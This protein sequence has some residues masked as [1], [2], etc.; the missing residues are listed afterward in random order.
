LP[1][2]GAGQYTCRRRYITI[3]ARYCGL[4]VSALLAAGEVAAQARVVERH[5]FSD[6]EGRLLAFYS[7]S[8]AFS[9]A[10]VGW[11]DSRLSF[12]LEVSHVPYLDK[13]QRRPSIDKPESTNLAPFFPRPR[14]SIGLGSWRAEASWIPPMRV[15]DVQANLG[16]LSITAPPVKI[17]TFRLS[18]RAWATIGRVEGAMTCSS[19]EML[20]H[21][22]DLELYYGTVCHGRESEDWFE[23]RMVG[24]EA[25]IARPLGS[26]GSSVYALAGAR[27]DR[28]RFDIGVLTFD[29]QRDPDH[30]ILQLSAFRPHG[31]IGGSWRVRRGVYAGGELFYAPGSLLT[32]RVSG[33]WLIRQ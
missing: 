17:G 26:G 3:P 28:T 10:G 20:G 29:G 4:A 21:G 6:P 25:V 27:V 15:F 8:M 12:S 31:A 33:R 22:A 18:P 23:P 5:E 16:S 9:P 1:I 7:A 13:A 24:G 19:Q 11:D 30:P 14:I 2:V 32:G